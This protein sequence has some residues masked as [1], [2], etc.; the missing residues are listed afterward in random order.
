MGANLHS[1]SIIL[2]L[3]VLQLHQSN[4]A[5][6]PP[7]WTTFNSHCYL[8]VEKYTDWLSAKGDCE[9]RGAGLASIHS[10]EEN[11]FITTL[12]GGNVWIGLDD[13]AAEGDFTWTDGSLLNFTNWGSNQ[14][15]NADNDEHCVD[16]NWRDPG[17]WNDYTCR[18]AHPFV[19]K[20]SSTDWTMECISGPCQ[21]GGQC[22]SS[23]TGFTCTCAFGWEGTN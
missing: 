3:V 14:P 22:T 5:N 12:T 16:F 19:C 7:D 18:S 23:G 17:I 11:E 6:C 9:G 2:M 8:Y 15:D 20:I 21:N 1:Y 13:V 10:S 4:G